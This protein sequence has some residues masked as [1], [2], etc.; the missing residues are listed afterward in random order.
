MTDP[1]VVRFSYQQSLSWEKGAGSRWSE[2]VQASISILDYA[3][4][5]G[6]MR[7][8]FTSRRGGTNDFMILLSIVMH[9]RPLIEPDLT[10]LI[11]LKM[12]AP[13]DQGRLYARITDMGLADELGM[14]RTTIAAS[15]QRLAKMGFI[16][17]VEISETLTHFR[18]SRGRF[19]GSK[20]YLLAGDLQERFMQK[21]LEPRSIESFDSGQKVR[22]DHQTSSA[23]YHEDTGRRTSSHVDLTDMD[24][25][26]STIAMPVQLT[27]PVDS[28]D[29]NKDNDEGNDDFS[30]D[31]KKETHIP[32]SIISHFADL[33]GDAY[34]ATYRDE[35]A[36][37]ALIED[38]YSIQEIL[39]GIERVAAHP[40]GFLKSAR[41]FAYCVPEIRKFAPIETSSSQE[42]EAEK[43]SSVEIKL[44]V[45]TKSQDLQASLVVGSVPDIILKVFVQAFGRV[46]S[47]T[48]QNRLYWLFDE[49]SQAAEEHLENAWDWIADGLKRSPADARQ[50]VAYVRTVVS[51][52]MRLKTKKLNRDDR[53]DPA[54]DLIGK[55][56]QNGQ[57]P[58]TDKPSFLVVS[59]PKNDPIMV[60]GLKI[61]KPKPRKSGFVLPGELAMGYLYEFIT[62]QTGQPDE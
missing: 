41:S 40:N 8:N 58:V 15:A 26:F 50:P 9:A 32:K 46:P 38:G 51:R 42:N 19:D 48:E 36:V 22:A 28:T 14:H 60:G 27:K 7:E 29:T 17:I 11:K 55:S 12:A 37:Q 21:T 43:T 44:P 1:Q 10:Y 53:N 2:L 5:S 34:M 35:Q 56:D 49:F 20:I 31:Q 54:A 62:N 33:R 3:L 23:P 52:Q 39:S 59:T 13:Q 25:K 57:D 30:L 45:L 47:Q 4:S 61:E 18:D 16:T 24:S 6:W